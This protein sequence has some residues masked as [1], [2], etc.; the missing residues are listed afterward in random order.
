MSPYDPR[1]T[2]LGPYTALLLGRL[3]KV[4]YAPGEAPEDDEQLEQ[5]AT[6]EVNGTSV[7]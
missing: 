5:E 6:R 4:T 2:I 3:P 7:N 1:Y